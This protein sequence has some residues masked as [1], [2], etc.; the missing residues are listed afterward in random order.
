MLPQPLL[1]PWPV[2]AFALASN[3]LTPE[4]KL[5]LRLSLQM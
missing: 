4:I 5:K 1:L 2:T 3:R